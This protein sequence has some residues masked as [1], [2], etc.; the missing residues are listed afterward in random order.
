MAF[1]VVTLLLTSGGCHSAMIQATVHN[2]TSG[3][4]K[5]IEVDYPSASFGTQ[6]L[7]SGADFE[8]RFKVLGSGDL[9]VLYTDASGKEHTSSGP[10]LHEGLEGQMQIDVVETGVRWTP[11]VSASR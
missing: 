5:L 4:L 3:P 7:A 1:P 9:K 6:D 11:K 8:Y 2:G 10:E